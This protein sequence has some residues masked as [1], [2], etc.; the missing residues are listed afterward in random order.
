MKFFTI[1]AP[2]I[3]A[4]AVYAHTTVKA[5]FINGV[6]QGNGENTYIRSP[7]NNNPVK[8]LTSDSVA[9]NVNNRAVPKTLEVSGGDVI[10]FEF[11][12]DNRGDDILASS[13]KGP[14]MVYVAPTSSNGKGAVWVKL[15]QEVYT[16]GQWASD[17]LIQNGGHVSITVPN[18]KAG[19]YL[20]RPEIVTLHEADAAYNVN[21]A[22]GVQL[23]MECV[24]FKVVSS[25]S[26]SLPAG[27]DFKTS[28]T[29]ADKGLVFNLYGSAATSYVAPGGAVSSIAGSNPGIGPVP[30]AGR[31]STV[32]SPAAG[33]QKTGDDSA[34]S[35]A[36][37]DD[38]KTGNNPAANPTPAGDQEKTNE[39]PAS[40]PDPKVPV[41]PAPAGGNPA[42]AGGNPAPADGQ[43][44]DDD[45][46]SGYAPAD[47]QKTGDD[48]AAN[49]TPAGDQ[50][51]A[52]EDP[53]SSPAPQA[54]VNPAPAGDQKKTDDAPASNYA[55]ADDPKKANDDPAAD[56]TPT[57]E[58]P[59]TGGKNKTG[60]DPAPSGDKNKT[61]NDPASRPD[62]KPTTEQ[63]SSGTAAK[64][65]QCGGRSYTG[66]TQCASG[67]TCKAINEWYSQCV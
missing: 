45:P 7:P 41:N 6:D 29:Y 24:Q 11:A 49:P 55:P 60:D 14:V 67:S 3:S 33:D 13:H 12:H 2:L 31:N 22:R 26:V 46:A 21:P 66:S 54:P 47:D 25:G 28:Y 20:F 17:K 44:T 56:P 39:D 15:H 52:N 59:K 37:A 38:Q 8:D 48:P 65:S 42:P 34:S 62:S 30:A 57:G 5:V 50:G 63:T 53:A 10:T 1:V 19:Q 32:N 9:C 35:Y 27:I 16:G 23:Y 58:K 4:S 61:D 18:L 40:S 51:K 43:K 36:P 64:Y